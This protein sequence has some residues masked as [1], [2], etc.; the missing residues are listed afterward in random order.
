MA[1]GKKKKIKVPRVVDGYETIVEIEVDD[2]G[3][4]AWGP[5]NQ[6]GCSTIACPEWMAQ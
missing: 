3:G 2:T 6:P 4:P 5:N 1:E